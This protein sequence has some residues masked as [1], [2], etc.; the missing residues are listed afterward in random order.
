MM[1]LNIREL[2]ILDIILLLSL[3]IKNHIFNH[4]SDLVS[5]LRS[6]WTG[7]MLCSITNNSAWSDESTAHKN[8]T[9]HELF[10]VSLNNPLHPNADLCS[11]SSL[12]YILPSTY[13]ENLVNNQSF[14]V[15]WSLPTYFHDQWELFI[16]H[17]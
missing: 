6:R 4:F 16:L 13:K 10:S 7:V 5:V 17:L 14:S 2:E 8:T 11:L 12:L 3:T 9:E 15:W 1:N